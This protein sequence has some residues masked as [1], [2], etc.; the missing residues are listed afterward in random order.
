MSLGSPCSCS[1]LMLVSLRSAR[2]LVR[3]PFV[4]IQPHHLLPFLAGTSTSEMPANH[5]RFFKNGRDQGIAFTDI[6]PGNSHSPRSMIANAQSPCLFPPGAPTHQQGFTFH[7]FRCTWAQRQRRT[8]GQSGYAH[9]R[10]T[11]RSS[12]F[13]R[14]G[15]FPKLSIYIFEPRCCPIPGSRLACS[16]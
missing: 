11:F 1:H 6:P 3:R 12:Q 8:L 14:S 2:S 15:R 7:Q 16:T 5:I 13:L 4:Q 9:Q 10:L